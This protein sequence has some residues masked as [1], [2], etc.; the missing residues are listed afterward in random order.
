MYN[1]RVRETLL[2]TLLEVEYN[3]V[4]SLDTSQ[5]IWKALENSFEGDEHSKNMRLQNWICAFQD[6]RMMEDESI[7]SYIGSI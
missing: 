2:S 3:Q 7:R 6:G 1:M 5:N 4:K